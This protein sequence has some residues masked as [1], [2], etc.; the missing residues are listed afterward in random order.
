M[1]KTEI[2]QAGL[3]SVA[4][5]GNEE[6]FEPAKNAVL[7]RIL[8]FSLL[9]CVSK[10]SISKSKIHL[11]CKHFWSASLNCADLFL[12]KAQKRRNTFRIPSIFNTE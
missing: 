2:L 12:I 8:H 3:L 7:K 9:P 10:A 4:S 5:L 11:Y 6:Q 1:T